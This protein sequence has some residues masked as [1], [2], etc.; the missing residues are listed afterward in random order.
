MMDGTDDEATGFWTTST[1]IVRGRSRLTF[2]RAVAA[3]MKRRW[4]S[5]C[6]LA[7]KAAT[8]YEVVV[9]ETYTPQPA[10]IMSGA[11]LARLRVTLDTAPVSVLVTY[12]KLPK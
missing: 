2:A 7:W 8:R 4:A 10:H 6:R 9:A 5:A 11:E 3:L 1:S 12:R